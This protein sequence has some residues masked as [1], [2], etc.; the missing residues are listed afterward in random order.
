MSMSETRASFSS[1]VIAFNYT[2]LQEAM[3]SLVFPILNLSMVR[4]MRSKGMRNAKER[5]AKL[6][7]SFSEMGITAS[8]TLTIHHTQL[9]T[10]VKLSYG[11]SELRTYGF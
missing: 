3:D 9:F 8:S 7:S 1:T 2:T 4:S 10:H 11:S 6:S 5:T